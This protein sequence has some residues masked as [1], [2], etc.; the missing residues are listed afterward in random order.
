[1]CFTL[2]LKGNF[3]KPAYVSDQVIPPPEEDE[4][5]SSLLYLN[6]ISKLGDYCDSFYQANLSKRTFPGIVSEVLRKKFY[7]NYSYYNINSNPLG[8]MM[9][10]IIG[11]GLTAVVIPDDIVKY[12][13]A[14]CS[15]Q[16]IVG[17]EIFKSRRF[18][19]RKVSMLDTVTNAGHFA[20][21]VYYEKSWHFFD[22]D[23]E[24]DA[25]LLREYKRPSTAFLAANPE[26]VLEA[27]C[28]Q[29]DPQVSKRLIMNHKLG[30]VNKFPAPNAYLFQ[31]GT[32]YF[33]Y[34][35]WLFFLA[36]IFVRYRMK[37]AKLKSSALSSA[38]KEKTASVFS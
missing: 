4:F 10:P 19:V 15:Q 22:T 23:Q 1:V 29:K 14:A 20:Y 12:P 18:P 34:F 26:L 3:A 36:I 17:M 13:Y 24:P 31:M 7:H 5:D 11:K 28:K 6:T 16:S 2:W 37:N 25:Q 33:N 38:R 32:K 27:Y 21:E 8:V 30:P 9:A 35:G